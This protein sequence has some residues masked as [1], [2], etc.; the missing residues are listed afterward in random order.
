M[1]SLAKY[2]SHSSINLGRNTPLAHLI[3]VYQVMWWDTP[4]EHCL[5]DRVTRSLN[6][7]CNVHPFYINFEPL[8][9]LQKHTLSCLSPNI[10]KPPPHRTRI[11]SQPLTC[12]PKS[13]GIFFNQCHSP[14][15]FTSASHSSY[16]SFLNEEIL[17]VNVVLPN[18]L[19]FSY[20]L[21]KNLK[22]IPMYHLQNNF[23][24]Q[25]SGLS[26]KTFH[27]V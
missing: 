17:R 2:R 7:A 3:V 5:R 6:F 18:T 22:P 21:T 24:Q 19:E 15:K 11:N 9:S 8:L 26:L 27:L 4:L 16:P 13:E 1:R 12:T 25:N 20:I 23:L 14:S 10:F